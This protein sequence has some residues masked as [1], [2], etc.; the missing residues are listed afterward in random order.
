MEPDPYP[1]NFNSGGEVGPLDISPSQTAVGVPAMRPGSA[2]HLFAS[3]SA[4]TR[5]RTIPSLLA[6]TPESSSSSVPVIISS[7]ATPIEIP[8]RNSISTGSTTSSSEGGSPVEKLGVA[9]EAISLDRGRDRSTTPIQLVIPPETQWSSL[10]GSGEQIVF[11]S[12]VEVRSRRRRLTASLLPAQ[13]R[14]KIRHLILTSSRLLLVK[15][16]PGRSVVLKNEALF[17]PLS[18]DKESERKD[19]K[20]VVTDVV[21]KGQNVFIVM[22]T[23]KPQQY[24]WQ[25]ASLVEKWITEI[26]NAVNQTSPRSRTESPISTSRAPLKPPL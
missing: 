8:S 19:G 25:E 26:H 4:D 22:T 21:A 13:H 9:I 23:G 10:L 14:P 18:K 16:K 6:V 11:Y 12:S 17:R 20:I 15:V 3:Y 7:G 1:Y 24:A 5:S 2:D